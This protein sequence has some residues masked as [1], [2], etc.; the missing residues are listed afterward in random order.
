MMCVCVSCVCMLFVRTCVLCVF[1]CVCEGE[2]EGEGG[3]ALRCPQDLVC[4]LS[5][6][7]D[8]GGPPTHDTHMHSSYGPP[9]P[10]TT[11]ALRAA[12]VGS[13]FLLR[14]VAFAVFAC[15][16]RYAR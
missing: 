8:G 6:R 12:L 13:S 1:V 2:G 11:H 7:A 4:A 10:V 5:V 3:D 14:D 16:L 9:L 15:V